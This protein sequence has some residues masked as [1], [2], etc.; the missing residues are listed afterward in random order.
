M[1]YRLKYD[2]ATYQM[3]SDYYIGIGILT[4][5]TSHNLIEKVFQKNMRSIWMGSIN[6]YLLM[7]SLMFFMNNCSSKSLLM[8]FVVFLLISS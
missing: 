7:L 2:L 8:V 6:Y 5:N 3:S 4:T 1:A